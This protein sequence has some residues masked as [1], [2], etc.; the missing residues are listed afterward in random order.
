MRFYKQVWG[1]IWEFN[2]LG[3]Y[4]CFVIGRIIGTIIVFGGMYLLV[5]CDSSDV[6]TEDTT[7]NYEV[8]PASTYEY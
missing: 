8:I 6:T 3:E 1:I 5:T 7:V 2:S 4:A